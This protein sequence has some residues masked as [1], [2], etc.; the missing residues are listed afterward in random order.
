M[1]AF[2]SEALLAWLAVGVAGFNGT[3]I[4]VYSH[5]QVLGPQGSSMQLVQKIRHTYMVQ[6][7]ED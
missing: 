7:E 3:C 4:V 5:F 2:S 6:K 1:F